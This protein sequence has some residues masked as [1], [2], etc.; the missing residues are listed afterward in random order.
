MPRRIRSQGFNGN[1]FFTS[2][3]GILKS[4]NTTTPYHPAGLPRGL[5]LTL[6]LNAAAGGF[7]SN[8]LTVAYRLV[9]G[10]KDA[11]NNY[12]YSAP[13]SRAIIKN[14]SGGAKNV[15]ISFL[16][17]SFITTQH[18]F[19]IY[20]SR[21]IDSSGATNIVAPS[22]NL[23]LVYERN[24]TAAEIAAREVTAAAPVTDLAPD[25]LLITPLYTNETQEGIIN[26][27]NI[28]PYS[29]DIALY[30]E[31]M[32][33]AYTKIQQNLTITLIGTPAVAGQTITVAG[34]T[35][36]AAAAENIPAGQFLLQSALATPSQNIAAT[37]TSLCR[38]INGFP[39]NVRVYAF[40][41]SN[42]NETPGKIFIQ[43]RIMGD[44]S[45][46]VTVSA[47]FSAFWEP[48]L[49]TV[50]T[51]LATSNDDDS[52]NALIISK[53]QQPEHCPYVNKFFVGAK[54]EAIQRVIALRDSVIIIKDQSIWR[55]VG[56]SLANFQ[57][58]L[59][60]NTVAIVSR[61][62]AA[63]LNNVVYMLSNQGIVTISD[64]GVQ[65]VGRNIEYDILADI[66]YMLKN[67]LQDE[68]IA[69]GHESDR[70]YYMTITAKADQ[71][72]YTD[73]KRITYVYNAFSQSWTRHYYFA[74]CYAVLGDRLY[75]GLNNNAGQLLKQR[76][77]YADQ[78][79]T[80]PAEM[81]MSDPQGTF[82]I[83]ALGPGTNQVTA[84]FTDGVDWTNAIN[85]WPTT[86]QRG[87]LILDQVGQRKYVVLNVVGNVYTLNSVVGLAVGSYTIYR[88][89]KMRPLLAP[90]TMEQPFQ[91]KAF[92]EAAFDLGTMSGYEFDVYFYNEKDVKDEPISTYFSTQNT[93]TRIALND[94]VTTTLDA[95]YV[96]HNLE[97][98]YVDKNRAVNTRLFVEI[99]NQVAGARFEI[100]A[101]GL[102]IRPMKSNKVSQ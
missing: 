75:W 48:Q 14:T 11:N 58:S 41:V 54:N 86:V 101:V 74:N 52:Q 91:L 70:N 33:Y 40:Y 19:Q 59:L 24:P 66:R 71:P 3:F 96:P 99:V 43:S 23:F 53:Q 44:A 39:G 97:R 20:R 56:S 32:V 61:D 78:T 89:I 27:N 26:E 17:P 10:V 37:A 29:R 69:I 67:N 7:L 5:D 68:P 45:W 77:G 50:A 57:I 60:D 88:G 92:S 35:Y 18:F 93:Q 28:P 2:N 84:T 15:D 102:D 34:T 100:N 16:I 98:T 94:F 83:T 73:G 51:S 85:S 65:I 1:I 87:W 82:Q 13:S 63:T 55:L 72:L 42:E 80:F 46:T 47:N 6:A 38:V 30:R 12:V 64:N 90:Q 9:W 81:E 36:A 25:S 31:H 49:P 4:E 22:D 8:N 79:P 76:N 21:Q 95:N 62:T